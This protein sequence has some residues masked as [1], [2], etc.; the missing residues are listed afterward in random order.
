[1]YLSLPLQLFHT[2]DHSQNHYSPFSFI[3]SILLQTVL[4]GLEEDEET[5]NPFTISHYQPSSGELNI[6]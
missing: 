5:T 4:R 6:D 3:L 1:L 2:K